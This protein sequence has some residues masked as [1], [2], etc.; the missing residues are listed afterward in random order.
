MHTISYQLYC[1]KYNNIIDIY[2]LILKRYQL[3][4]YMFTH[5]QLSYF[6]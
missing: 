6:Y 1:K 5:L 2:T 3:L 4:I